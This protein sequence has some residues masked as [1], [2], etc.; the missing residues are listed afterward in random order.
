MASLIDTVLLL[1]LASLSVPVLVL[2]IEL[3]LALRSGLP[4]AAVAAPSPCR[5]AVL[6][7]AHNEA[8]G[9][10]ATL[11]ALR[12]QLCAGDRL[13]VVA[14]NCSDATA[15]IARAGRAEVVERSDPVRRGKGYAL[16]AGMRHLAAQPPE[17]VIIVDADCSVAAGAIAALAAQAQRSGAPV[18]ARY[19]MHAPQAS[20]AGQRIAE[21]AWTIKNVVR[22]LGLAKAGLPCQLM[23]SGMAFPWQVLAGVNLAHGHLV[24]D[25]QLGIELCMAG[26]P[27]QFCPAALVS[28]SFPASA[29]GVA[30]QRARWEHGHLGVILSM[31]P[32]GLWLAVRRRDRALAALLLDL[33][34]PPLALLVLLC[35]SLGLLGLAVLLAWQR[36][37]PF[38]ISVLQ[39]AGLGI[40]LLL[41]ARRFARGR[42]HAADL[43]GA[44]RYAVAKLPL[45]LRFLRARQTSWVRTRRD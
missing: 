26:R 33:A 7:P 9:L 12:P 42:L 14:D 3:G 39:L 19:V 32:P 35:A 8:A 6:I 27:P 5:V 40:A 24:E 18:Q 13:V 20:L 10:A 41:A 29:S 45:Y 16:D 23:G 31:V 36:W 22:P 30:S 11:D 28:S 1:S 25:M 21:F 17:V 38:L 15:A 4:A 34:V 43:A 37:L 44:L 2:L